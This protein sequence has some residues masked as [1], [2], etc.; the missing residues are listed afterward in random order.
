VGAA[1]GAALL[2]GLLLVLANPPADAGPLVFVALVPLL[3]GLRGARSR[4]GAL[5]GFA[6]GLVYYGLLLEWLIVFGWV[7]WLPLVVSQALF[8]AAFGALAPI[9]GRGGPLRSSLALAALWTAIDW[10]RGMWPIGGFTWGGL[11]YTQ[12]GN[13]LTLPL[14]TVTGVWGVTFVVVLVNALLLEAVA[15]RGTGRLRWRGAPALVAAALAVVLLPALIPVRGAAG[16]AIDVAVVQGS[17]PRALASDRL[18][19]GDQ[20]ALNHID[21][22]RTLAADPPD[23]AV[24][25]ENALDADPARDPTLGAAVS[26]SIR[27]VGAPTIVGAISPA[28]GGALFNRALLYDGNGR[29]VDRY[30][31]IHLVPFGE[32][33]PLRSALGWTQRYRHGL[34]T[35]T[36][37]TVV[38]PFDVG[39]TLVGTPICFENTFPGL[40]R[41][42]VARGASLVV[43]TTNDSSYLESPASREHVVMSQLR[44]VETGRWIVQ[45]A[46]SGES[47]VVNAHGQVV[48]RTGLFEQTVLRA[49]VPTSTGETLYVRLGDWFPVACVVAVLV[50]LG[51]ALAGRTG[52]RTGQDAGGGTAV[53]PPAGED[54]AHRHA[55]IAGA[56]DPRV[57]VVIPTYNEKVTIETVVHGVLAAGP[58]VHALIVDDGSPDGTGAIA[59]RLAAADPRVRVLHRDGKRGLA[60][61]YLEG[62]HLA[63]GDGYDV[64]VEM[65]ADL[66]HRPEDLPAVIGG[67]ATNDLTIGSRYIPGGA[68]SNWSR[69][70][71]AL[72]KGGNAYARILLNLPVR[73]ATSGFRSYRRDV[74]AALVAPGFHSQGYG[75][76]IELVYRAA[77]MGY[78]L[79]EVPITFREREHGHSKISRAIVVEALYDVARWG[80]RDR[81][82][83]VRGRRS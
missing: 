56:A 8:L 25:P 58:S 51:L 27:D 4:W 83:R 47:A 74:L 82:A 43:V 11:G 79:G 29:I 22:N 2:S 49:D 62:F 36:A 35:F 7:A 39:G 46:V 59:D 77:R 76:Q 24:W 57:L 23:L 53:D 9:A 20:V 64:V 54:R 78:R 3:W 32:Y 70:R 15:P 72:S 1:I 65:D 5:A 38:H 80:I 71:V 10:V 40:F 37:G 16:P 31:K 81:L 13:G 67:S 68:V 14:A 12:H 45:A 44:A 17:V 48:R 50:L 66:S 26:A 63:L 30:T 69:F 73:D 42:F 18:L 41:Q 52:E 28:P 75:F 21:L 60:S 61:A 34:P 55:P 33:I 19:Q 6:C